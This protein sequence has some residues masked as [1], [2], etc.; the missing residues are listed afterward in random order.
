M[1]KSILLLTCL[2]LPFSVVA[3]DKYGNETVL[4][5]LQKGYKIVSVTQKHDLIFVLQKK[6]DLV[7]CGVE[8]DAETKR[9]KKVKDN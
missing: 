8:T 7:L 3:K 4:D 9:C 2:L 1:K 6:N 5:Y